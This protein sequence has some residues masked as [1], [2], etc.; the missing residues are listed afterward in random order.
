MSTSLPEPFL[1]RFLLGRTRSAVLSYLYRDP[2]RSYYLRQ[3][4]KESG[5]SPGAVQREIRLLVSAG[6]VVRSMKGNQPFY[7][8]N[9]QCLVYEEIRDFLRKTM[10]CRQTAS[11]VTRNIL[12][13]EDKIAD[14]CRRHYITRLSFFGSVLRDDFDGES[15]IDVLV[16]FAPGHVPGWAFF[17]IEEELSQMLGRKVE[18]STPGDLSKHIRDDVVREA[19][20]H[21]GG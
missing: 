3:V 19:E 7:C 2:A 4:I 8:A 20:I 21:Y 15:D 5:G 11:R 18:L 6:L 17:G 12:V 9:R 10:F 13:P 14:L 1:A 16:E